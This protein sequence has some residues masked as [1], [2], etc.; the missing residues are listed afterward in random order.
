MPQVGI[1]PYAIIIPYDSEVY[2]Q[3]TVAVLT[4]VL[5]A[6]G[7]GKVLVKELMVR[8]A[9]THYIKIT[10]DGNVVV[11]DRFYGEGGAYEYGVIGV[12]DFNQSILIEHRTSAA[13][14]NVDLLLSYYV[15]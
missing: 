2:H 8:G 13:A 7:R 3:V 9:E 15:I 5:N 11:N 14:T 6:A 12:F 1:I 4:T 10:V